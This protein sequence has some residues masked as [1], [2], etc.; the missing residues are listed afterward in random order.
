MR[1]DA[2]RNRRRIVD[3]AREAYAQHGVDVPMATIARAAGVGVATLY[4]R[5]PTRDHLV[6]EVFADQL[7]A[8]TRAF[9]EALEDP[10]PWRGF[11]R[12]IEKICALQAAERGFT[13]AFLHAFPDTAADHA[14]L[15][16]QG[17][18]GFAALVRRAQQAGS[19]RPDFHPSDLV[20]VLVANS[21]LG[22]TPDPAAASQRLVGLLLDSFRADAVRPPLPP[23][24]GLD[25]RQLHPSTADRRTPAP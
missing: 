14:E 18:R 23:P 11:C 21:A 2:R 13:A 6:R 24:T 19:L 9:T 15:R 1:A 8:C 4:R 17:E 22:T 7:D 20:L 16:L 25:L 10:D 5:F 12:V 3:A